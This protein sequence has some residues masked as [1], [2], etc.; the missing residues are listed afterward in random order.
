MVLGVQKMEDFQQ[1]LLFNIDLSPSQNIAE[2]SNEPG[3]YHMD[4][5][6]FAIHLLALGKIKGI[7]V[8]TLRNI[9]NNYNNLADL[10]DADEKSFKEV[11]R[12]SKI[13]D[14]DTF[15][16]FL[17][18]NRKTILAEAK[19]DFVEFQLQNIRL[20]PSYSPDFP[21]S[22]KNIPGGPEW[23][24]V[25]GN[26]AALHSPLI[27]IVGTRTPSKVAIQTATTLSR[28]ICE[29]GLSVVSGLAEGIDNMAHRIAAYYEAPQVAVLGTGITTVFP[30]STKGT[31]K[32]IIDTGGAV[33]TEF[34][35]SEYYNR[36]QFVERNR[37][38]AGLA[39]AL[40]PIESLKT[41]GTIHTVNFA[42]KYGKPIFGARFGD[43]DSKNQLIEILEEHQHPIFNL[44][45]SEEIG[46][47]ISWLKDKTVLGQWPL[48]KRAINRP[49]L[50]QPILNQIDELT[51]YIPF[52]EED[53]T[54]LKEQI[55]TR[56]QKDSSDL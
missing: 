55:L 22:L 10:W 34:L 23:L 46:Q 30:T 48:Q 27:G 26:I 39:L 36:S 51:S 35:P 18:N 49:S 38:Q 37:I 16:T 44:A 28:I 1:S 17:K 11:L 2:P 13:K 32:R 41:G 43:T 40:A 5:K 24:F 12:R 29:E 3:P 31:R 15:L 50:F 54:W 25:E 19:R 47:L 20:M 53:R 52:N 8:H 45:I 6:E 21:N 14:V 4:E 42:E 56:L 9:V 7:G 33:I